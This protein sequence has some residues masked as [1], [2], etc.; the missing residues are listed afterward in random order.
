MPI[1]LGSMPRR[2]K[3]VAR[4]KNR[5]GPLLKDTSETSYVAQNSKLYLLD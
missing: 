4:L 1:A 3:T 5:H 2:S